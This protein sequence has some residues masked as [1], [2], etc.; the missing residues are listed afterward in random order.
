MLVLC[1]ILLVAWCGPAAARGVRGYW[2]N[3]NYIVSRARPVP[4][5]HDGREYRVHLD[6][7]DSSGA[8]DTLAAL[9]ARAIDLMAVLRKKY[10]TAPAGGAAVP[11][12]GAAGFAARREIARRLLD[13]Y[14]RDQLVESSPNNPGGD[15]SYTLNKGRLLA[16]C[17]REKDPA[18]I[19]SPDVQD[20]HD[21]DTLWFVT[22]HELAHLGVDSIGHPPEFWSAFKFLL[23]ECADAGLTPAG[24]WPDY[25]R[26]PILYC[27]L[28]VD[29]NPLFDPFTPLP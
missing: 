28:K 1:V 2:D 5:L 4:A 13:R 19:G 20:I 24:G 9:H 26:A 21:L 8:A 6:H 15:T 18:G 23:T 3:R 10:L 22:V 16:L 7:F 29:Y 17:I 25:G 27:G 12:A 11:A 14:D